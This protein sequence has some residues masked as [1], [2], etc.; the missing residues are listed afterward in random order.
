MA[1]AAILLAEQ[2]QRILIVLPTPHL[3]YQVSEI[4]RTLSPST[5]ITIPISL[6]EKTDYAKAIIAIGTARLLAT[7]NLKDLRPT[8]IFLDEPDT[9][10]G[11]LPPRKTPSNAL[12]QIQFVK[13]PPYTV[14]ILEKLVREYET[15]PGASKPRTVWI[16]ATMTSLTRRTVRHRGWVEGDVLDLDFSPSP[17]SKAINDREAL[18]SVGGSGKGDD[19][20][21]VTASMSLEQDRNRLPRKE[22]TGASPPV[23]HYALSVEPGTGALSNVELPVQAFRRQ[24]KF[25]ET[26]REPASNQVTSEL[27]EATALL[28][29]SVPIPSG[30]VALLLLPEGVS[31]GTTRNRLRDLGVRVARIP[32]E[33][34]KDTGLTPP[35]ALVKGLGVGVG[36]G[37]GN[38]VGDGNVIIEPRSAMPGLHIPNLSRVYLLAGLDLAR[39][40]KGQFS[41][42]LRERT[43]FYE[44]VTGRMGRMGS[45]SPSSQDQQSGTTA[46]AG[47]VFSLILAE[48]GEDRGI[49][50]IFQPKVGEGQAKL[51]RWDIEG[52]ASKVAAELELGD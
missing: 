44:I 24:P 41:K 12:K 36:D 7:S 11:P 51:D 6:S 14:A 46:I 50:A 35:G 20:H 22:E 21:S 25:D 49:E 16:S 33:K 18:R 17:S 15:I 38:G 30:T 43:V 9:L 19:N 1:L 48:S 34:G 45:A 40:P 32:S 8:T 42:R 47:E 29:H 10:F 4:I 5:S 52:M 31:G 3:V 23:K 26:R 2:N 37:N 39:V 28:H 27:L 13:N